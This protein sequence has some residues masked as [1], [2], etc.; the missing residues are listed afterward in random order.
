[1]NDTVKKRKKRRSSGLGANIL[2]SLIALI[3]L[4]ACIVVMLYNF[5]MKGT[6][7]QAEAENAQLR[8]YQ[9]THPYSEEDLEARVEEAGRT[10][11]EAA[12]KEILDDIMQHMSD[13]N[14][15]YSLL[16]RLYPEDVVV[17]ADGGY[18]FFPITDAYKHHDLLP[19]NFYRDEES[20]EVTYR[21][22]GVTVHK[23]ID[24]S[25]YNG[26]VDWEKVAA[27]GIEYAFI[28]AGYR[29]STEGKLMTDE[30]FRDNMEGALENGI[31]VGVYFFTQAVSEKEGREEAEYVLDLIRDYDVTYPIVLDV[32]SYED[33][34]A[35]EIDQTTRTDAAIAF[36]TTVQEAGY[37]PM[38]YANLKGYFVMLDMDRI[39]GYDKWFAYY[40]YPLYMPYDIKIW[41]YT[42][43]GTVDGI[44]GDCDLNISFTD[45]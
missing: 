12:R 34:R 8:A 45:Y 9:D 6:L 1:M 2:F 27:D 38:L 4:T 35:D 40:N 11:D 32:E 15:A 7:D 42:A 23:G 20:G 39:E 36:L 43:K 22:E 19:E 29:G 25:R 33:S 44:K 17:M 31:K 21:Q 13:G 26:T 16:Q 18:R 14:S 5:T 37:R 41:Q 30:T 24:V 3:S 10:A 28:R